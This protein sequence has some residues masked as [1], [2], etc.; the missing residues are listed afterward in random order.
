LIESPHPVA[1]MRLVGQLG[2][3]HRQFEHHSKIPAVR[4]VL[5]SLRSFREQLLLFLAAPTP[6]LQETSL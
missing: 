3:L 1:S 4:D 5:D 6:S 2:E